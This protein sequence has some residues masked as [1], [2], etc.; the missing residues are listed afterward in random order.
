[1]RM[2]GTGKC[3]I[4]LTQLNRVTQHLSIPYI[5]PLWPDCGPTYEDGEEGP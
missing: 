4:G 5:T 2:Q 1:M 3:R